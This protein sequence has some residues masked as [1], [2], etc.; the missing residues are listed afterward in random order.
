MPKRTLQ[1]CRI[2]KKIGEKTRREVVSLGKRRV[3][4]KASKKGCCET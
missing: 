1:G 3:M 4:I 2:G